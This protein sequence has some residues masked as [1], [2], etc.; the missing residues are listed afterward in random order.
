MSVPFGQG[1]PSKGRHSPVLAREDAVRTAAEA[2]L[3]HADY[4]PLRRIRCEYHEG[5]LTLRGSV[6]TYHLKQIAQTLVCSLN[7]I[8]EVNNRLEVGPAAGGE[9]RTSH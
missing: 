8:L 3:R 7:G 1:Q 2:T 4:L 9:P 6:P 5:V